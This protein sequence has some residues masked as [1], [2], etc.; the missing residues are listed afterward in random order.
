M[1]EWQGNI[2][3]KYLAVANSQVN[4]LN[5]GNNDMVKG[6]NED[7]VK[8]ENIV[9]AIRNGWKDIDK[10]NNKVKEAM[11]KAETAKDTADAAYWKDAGNFLGL[12]N[13]SAIEKLQ[14]A[15]R[16]LAGA[17]S[18]QAEAQT[19]SF[20]YQKALADYS[21]W[22]L[23]LG[24]MNI[25][26]SRSIVRELTE[27]LK[28]AN[29]E[30][31]DELAQKELMAVVEQ[32]KMQEDIYQRVIEVEKVCAEQKEGLWRIQLKNHELENK[33]YEQ[34]GDLQNQ[35]EDIVFQK[36][37]TEE[38]EQQLH[39]LR[40]CDDRQTERIQQLERNSGAQKKVLDEIIR[41]NKLKDQ[42]LSEIGKYNQQQGEKLKQVNYNLKIYEEKLNSIIKESESQ[43]EVLAR[44]DDNIKANMAQIQKINMEQERKWME[45]RKEKKEQDEKI[46]E[47]ENIS[48]R[49]K[50]S[51]NSLLKCIQNHDVKFEEQNGKNGGQEKRIEDLLKINQEQKKQILALE[52]LCSELQQQIK[53]E[54]ECI[55]NSK[56]D[57]Q[58]Q[59]DM[60]PGKRIVIG[61]L[62]CSTIALLIIAAQYTLS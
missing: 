19:L 17:V 53:D 22:L 59:I 38:H 27:R 7:I 11:F 8:R 62:G 40:N 3:D 4:T 60:R 45:Q 14:V 61:S 21:R 31:L 13:K 5:T 18:I 37:I 23:G 33:F 50:E 1:A 16:D 29:S 42:M 56:Q 47:Q 12:A 32:L 57:L 43:K 46:T 34:Q 26:T 25:A 28:G 2:F 36:E 9:Q 30:E 54:K 49:H 58:M 35:S 51:L 15:T 24:A 52:S 10:L 48:Q 44:Q 55:E 6:E 20:E 41:S 39:E